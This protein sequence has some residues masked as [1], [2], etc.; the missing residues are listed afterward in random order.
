[1]TSA[2]KLH[3]AEEIGIFQNFLKD[4]FRVIQ[5]KLL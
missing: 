1:M 4:K 2:Y 5:A 3:K